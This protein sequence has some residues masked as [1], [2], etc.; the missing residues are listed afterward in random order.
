MEGGNTFWIALCGFSRVC[1]LKWRTNAV[2][3]IYR[4]NFTREKVNTSRIHIS[5]VNVRKQKQ[6]KSFNNFSRKFA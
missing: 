3:V 4:G 5:I 2:C 6:L 1:V